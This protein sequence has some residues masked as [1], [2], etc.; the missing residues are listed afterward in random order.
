MKLHGIKNK[1]MTAADKRK[2]IGSTIGMAINSIII[3]AGTVWL[4]SSMN[5][6]LGGILSA[7]FIWVAFIATTQLAAVLWESKKFQL[8]LIDAGYYLAALIVVGIITGLM[9]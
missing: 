5:G 8:Y 2:M 3:S 9:G 1:K 4:S 6:V 7:L